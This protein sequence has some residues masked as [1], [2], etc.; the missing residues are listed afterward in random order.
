MK[1][2][3][4]DFLA[5]Y[6]FYSLTGGG[7]L[8]WVSYFDGSSLWAQ[9]QL[10]SKLSDLREQQEYYEKEL[11]KVKI[12]EREVM[13]TKEAM[14]KFAREKYLMKKNGETIFIIVDENNQSVDKFEDEE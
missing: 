5:K 7:L 8:I 3:I 6:H 10:R 9:I 4:I 2:K 12:E 14:E 13:G 11:K 1:K